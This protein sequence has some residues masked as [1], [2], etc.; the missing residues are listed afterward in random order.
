MDTRMTLWLDFGL[1]PEVAELLARHLQLMWTGKRFLHMEGACWDGDLP[2]TVAAALFSSWRFHRFSFSR[3]LTVGTACRTM[4]VAFLTGVA[5]LVQFIKKDKS[6]SLFFLRGF[7]RLTASRL[8]FMAVAAV[9][10]RVPEAVQADLMNDNR[11]AKAADSLWETAAK[12]VKWVID[13]PD[14]TFA[15]LA[16]LFDKTG[17][18]VKDACINAAHV[19]FHFM[20]RRFLEVAGELPW[21]LCRGNIGQ[22]LEDLAADECPDEPVS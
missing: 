3:W 4:I 6:N 1:A 20:Y 18:A 9:V 12:E 13:L 17:P 21:S 19:S 15:L 14:S 8:E 10:G 11:V 5:G 22:N 7:D 2:G 16:E